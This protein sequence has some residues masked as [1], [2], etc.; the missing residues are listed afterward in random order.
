MRADDRPRV[1][2]V[3]GTLLAVDERSPIAAVRKQLAAMRASSGPWLDLR[4][5]LLAAETLAGQA[6]ARRR[7]GSWA[8][9][10]ERLFSSP[11]AEGAPELTEVVLMTLLAAESI[12]YE[13]A[14]F[15]TL[16]AD[17]ALRDTLLA[18]CDAVFVSSTLLRDASELLP[19]V[20]RLRR[21]GNRVVVGGALAPLLAPGF[22]GHESIDVLAVGEGERLVPALA[23]WLRG[24][25]LRA[26]DGGRIERAGPTIV[27]HAGPSPGRSLD[28]LPRPDWSLAEQYH[29]R[30]L[31]M[32]F[33]ESVRGCP[34]RCAFCNY[35]YLFADDRFRTRS[36]EAIADDWTAY[37][38]AGVRWITCLDSL[39]TLPP[40]RLDALCRLLIER[41]LDL[42]W[43]CYARADD[44]CDEDRVRRMRDAGC[45]QVQIGLESGDAGQ[46][47]RMDKRATPEQGLRALEV[48]RR[49]G[50][51]TL[52]TF[53]VGFPGETEATVAATRDLI[54]AGR[55][56]FAYL[57][58]FTTRVEGVPVLGPESRARYG[59]VTTQGITS[60]APYWR[61]DTMSAA[62]V[63]DL[64][65]RTNA[66]IVEARASLDATLFYRTILHYE[67]ARD[68]EDLL[69]FQRDAARSGRVAQALLRGVG[70]WAQGRLRRDLDQVLRTSGTPSDGTTST[71]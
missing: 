63:P 11:W 61:H 49:V 41:R 30:K 46:L 21:A 10:V 47:E 17:R 14:T 15:A 13:A 20:A 64:L 42:R 66:A 5:K 36:A 29:G 22:A 28:D 24:G 62:D 34:Y 69:D 25:E 9:T 56:D 53:I 16:L 12:A 4:L 68:R 71:S 44:L 58:P 26:P 43:I 2:I 33:Y 40:R 32:V 48:C 39:F 38:R 70:V 67:R 27:L 65:R 7:G 59:L 60:S 3:T 45:V 18:R 57:A 37:A 35:P 52:C 55:P 19:L 6:A 8:G 54:L 51:T 31:P 50:I 1:L 23:A